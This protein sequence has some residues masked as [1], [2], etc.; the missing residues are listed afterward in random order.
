MLLL[1][2]K[3]PDTV[4]GSRKYPAALWRKGTWLKGTRGLK[5]RSSLISISDLSLL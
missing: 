1:D 3:Y 5:G 2:L 4:L